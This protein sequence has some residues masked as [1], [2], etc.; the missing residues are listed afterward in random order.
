MLYCYTPPLVLLY[1]SCTVLLPLLSYFY[2]C[3]R[4]SNILMMVWYCYCHSI[5]L[6]LSLLYWLDHVIL[7]LLY[8]HCYCTAIVLVLLLLCT[9]LYWYCYCTSVLLL[10][11][12][13]G[14]VVVILVLL[15]YYYAVIL[16]CSCC[17][18]CYTGIASVLPL[19]YWRALLL[20]LTALMSPECPCHRQLVLQ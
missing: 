14:P 16:A 9:V 7:L 3:F 17:C 13:T 18:C 1:P 11:C 15:L 10:C 6:I 4:C 12:Y 19:L 5:P 8:W 2:C 20:H